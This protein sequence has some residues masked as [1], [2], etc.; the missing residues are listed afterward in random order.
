MDQETQ[1]YQE[2]GE[3]EVGSGEA[4]V[5]DEGLLEIAVGVISGPVVTLRRVT[6]Q[7]P[8]GWALGLS[9]VIYGAS[10][11]VQGAVVSPSDFGLDPSTGFRIG[12]LLGGAIL[13]P[14]IGLV[15]LAFW[16]GIFQ[17]MSMILG[18]KGPYSGLFAG[19]AFASVPTVFGIPVTLLTAFLGDAGSIMSGLVQLG[20]AIWIIVLSAIVIRENN[21]FSTGRAAVALL[22][23]LAIIFA[24]LMALVIL[25][26]IALVLAAASA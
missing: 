6:R 16:A 17:L 15:W 11:L 18:G 21:G 24:L 12:A 5:T 22:V 7:R 1:G 4:A 8:I 20:L 2:T 13:L 9:V 25:V 3:Q 10:G 19:L 14:L 26:V 23:P